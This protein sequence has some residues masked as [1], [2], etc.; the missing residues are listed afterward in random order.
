MWAGQVWAGQGWWNR[1]GQ[2]NKEN[3]HK[4][5][6]SKTYGTGVGGRWDRVG[7]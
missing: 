6:L 3:I 4:I 1:V 7:R 5:T 2:V